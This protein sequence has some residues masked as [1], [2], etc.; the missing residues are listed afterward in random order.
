[1][2]FLRKILDR[3]WFNWFFL[4]SVVVL[5]I[6][7][8]AVF[9]EW[10]INTLQQFL[11]VL[12]GIVPV[13]FFVYFF[14]FVFNLIISNARIQEKLKTSSNIF[15]YIISVFG[16]ILSTWPV[17]LWYPFLKQLRWYWLNNWHITSFVY[18]RAIKIPMFPLMIWYFWLLYT[19]SFNFVLLIFAFIIWPSINL[20][21]KLFPDEK[22]NSVS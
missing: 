2:I 21:F 16:W 11:K 13:L 19:I 18:A 1:M 14:I 22:N 10:G 17:Y 5:Y 9:P 8:L 20:F 7:F 4:L 12:I 3:L 6:L 15:K